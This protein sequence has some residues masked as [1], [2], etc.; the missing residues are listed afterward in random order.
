MTDRD[1]ARWCWDRVW[2]GC[3]KSKAP[4][5]SAA[6][7]LYT[8]S[9]FASHR[10]LI[11]HLGLSLFEPEILSAKH[12]VIPWAT[13]ID[14]YEAEL[15]ADARKR[16]DFAALVEAEQ[17]VDEVLRGRSR[18]ADPDQQSWSRVGSAFGPPLQPSILVLAGASYIEGW[19]ARAEALGVRVD[20]PLAG[21]TLGA[22]RSFARR[23]VAETP[24]W[25][26]VTWGEETPGGWGS[27]REQ[28]FDFVNA[29]DMEVALD[30]LPG[31][32][33][34]MPQLSLGLESGSYV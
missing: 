4:T 11:D 2:I 1:R 17:L 33:D 19:V 16:L 10:A 8:G 30:D 12:G 22:R 18:L 14:P 28:L 34:P 7:D 20:A 3:G 31:P 9:L 21:M 24:S 5:R 27:R 6:G 32:R 25:C 15:D 26:D 23:F 13:P 29:V